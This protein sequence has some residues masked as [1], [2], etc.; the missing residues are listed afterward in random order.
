MWHNQ[1]CFYSGN[2]QLCIMVGSFTDSVASLIKG[3]SHKQIRKLRNVSFINLN[4]HV[5]TIMTMSVAFSRDFW[6]QNIAA[7]DKLRNDCDMALVRGIMRGR[8]LPHKKHM[9]FLKISMKELE[10]NSVEHFLYQHLCKS[11][12]C[13]W[14]K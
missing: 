14:Y 2:D 1:F 8:S 6:K 13:T 9:I 10:G 3:I 11:F 12:H 4:P 5:E 7:G